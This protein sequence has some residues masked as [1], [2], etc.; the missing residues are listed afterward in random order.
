M[1][2]QAARIPP[3]AALIFVLINSAFPYLI[4]PV[5][6]GSPEPVGPLG[7]ISYRPSSLPD[8][9]VQYINHSFQFSLGQFYLRVA[10]FVIYEGQY[11][12]LKQI[13]QWLQNNYPQVQ[14]SWLIE[15]GIRALHYGYNLTK[16]P[17]GVAD[18]LDY[19][20]FRLVD[21]N[22][23]LSWIS[24]RVEEKLIG[25]DLQNVT[26]ICIEK[27]NLELSFEDLYQW[28]YTVEHTNKTWVLIG[29]VRGETDL[30]IDPITY[31]YE[32]LIYSD[33]S[34]DNFFWE[35]WNASDSNGWDVVN[36][37]CDTQFTFWCPIQI[38]NATVSD[39]NKQIVFIDLAQNDLILY[40]GSSYVCFGEIA[41][42]ERKIGMNGCHFISL[43][44]GD[45]T[46]FIKCTTSNPPKSCGVE[47]YGC[48][49]SHPNS[50]LG[51]IG[52]Y[53]SCNGSNAPFWNG[54]L[55]NTML[56]HS[57]L[58][59][60]NIHS[61]SKPNDTYGVYELDSGSTIDGCSLHGFTYGFY[62]TDS[63]TLSGLQFSGNTYD[64]FMVGTGTKSYN[65]TDTI[66]DWSIFWSGSGSSTLFRKY[67]FSLTV[68][69]E[70]GS[71]VE[72]AQVT[73]SYYGNGGGTAYSGLSNSE[74]EISTTLTMGYYP[75]QSQSLTSYNPYHI[76]IQK[77]G[78]TYY[79]GNFT[80]NGSRS[81]HIILQE[82][83]APSQGPYFSAQRVDYGSFSLGIQAPKEIHPSFQQYLSNSLTLQIDLR[84]E[85][86]QIRSREFQLSYELREGTG[87][88]RLKGSELLEVEAGEYETLSL[89]LVEPFSKRAQPRNYT[90]TISVEVGRRRYRPIFW[91]I[92]ISH[93]L[94]N[95]RLYSGVFL[96]AVVGLLSLGYG[97]YHYWPRIQKEAK[98]YYG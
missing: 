25:L 78:T 82:E 59:L 65:F 9:E 40:D 66:A 87:E 64:F 2:S 72:G 8:L 43:D 16:L 1:K 46:H 21:L 55:V 39:M 85:N 47:L 3:I 57:K 26:L 14:Y 95:S 94:W 74:G 71:A 22:F 29:Q 38:D 18:K 69:Y 70:N 15:K 73:L 4:F 76:S 75:A 97:L 68:L 93:D 96:M 44:V 80:L 23:P 90:L 58:D 81:D 60:S 12:G 77:G 30:V 62:A 84:L 52:Y 86:Y 24:L 61:V 32:T 35:L 45:V 5:A 36:N 53:L 91:P 6:G 10:P 27:A 19:L 49:F 88:L 11:Y 79:T 56:G 51:V 42:S 20:G 67:T 34:T 48:S 50:G 33:G 31:S 17:Q 63:V 89:S 41:D 37:T 98:T 7:T 13:L 92:R 83:E 54:L 28:G